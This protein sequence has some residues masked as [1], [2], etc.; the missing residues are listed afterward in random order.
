M[1]IALFFFLCVPALRFGA[2][3]RASAPIYLGILGVLILFNLLSQLVTAE[4][5]TP[6][7]PLMICFQLAFDL[8]A[9]SGLLA[10]SGG[11][12]NPFVALFF[13][14][15]SL[16]GLLIPG[17][18]S[19]PFLLLTHTLLGSLQFQ[20]LVANRGVA[21][22]SLIS[23]FIVS[24]LMVL[25]FWLVM[26]SLGAY[27]E[28]Q[29]ERQSQAQINL[30]KQ[31]RLRSIGALAAG[32]SHEFASPLNVLKI[33]LERLSRQIGESEETR[34]ALKA[35][36]NCQKIIQQMNSSQMDSRDF[37]FKRL[38]VG[39]L[40][41]DVVESWKEDKPSAQVVL[42]I[43][44]PIMSSLPPINF[45]QVMI[46]LLDNA[47]EANAQGLIKID[48]K[49]LDRQICLSISDEG[50]GFQASVLR[51]RGEP[52]LTTKENG[53][54][55]GLY[56]SELFVQSLGGCLQLMNKREGGATVSMCW[57]DREAQ[58]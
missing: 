30:E 13:L 55:L 24:H 37:H 14:N 44:N 7:G 41:R 54:G 29:S 58:V 10:V 45:S 53:T 18:L 4:S 20:I 3:N 26:R 1:A 39:D 32:F 9:L 15:V 35:V 23:S 49:S 34:E 2:L 47:F 56:V 22:G 31:D 21:D 19:L 38:V 28:N 40:L 57:P 48:L 16:G 27:L 43:V 42:N 36:L 5:K 50:P 11:F 52:F 25:G 46:N 51:Q 33:R 17:R 12:S 6:I 8:L